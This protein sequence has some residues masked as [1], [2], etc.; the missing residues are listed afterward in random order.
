M[1]AAEDNSTRA[2]TE[3]PVDDDG[4]SLTLKDQ[5]FLEYVEAFGGVLHRAMRALGG[6]NYW[7]KR[8]KAYPSFKKLV[9]EAVERGTDGLEDEIVRRAK[10][11]VLDP[12]YHQG[13]IVGHR[14][15]FSDRLAE[16]ILS[17]RRAKYRRARTDQQGDAGAGA[18]DVVV[19]VPDNG[20]GPSEEER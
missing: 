20:R 3:T 18:N 1:M 17:G 5:R 14:V 4:F 7:Y 19:F 13:V 8:M 16:F 12:V 10:D 9:D 15:L 11:G 2:R 6:T